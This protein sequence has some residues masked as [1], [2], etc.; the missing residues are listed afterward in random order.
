MDC[1]QLIEKVMKDTLLEMLPGLMS[2][3]LIRF[4]R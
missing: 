2:Q 3:K 1:E 4:L